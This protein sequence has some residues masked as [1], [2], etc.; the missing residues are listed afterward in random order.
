MSNWL[1]RNS[2]VKSRNDCKSKMWKLKFGKKSFFSNIFNWRWR[3]SDVWIWDCHLVVELLKRVWLLLTGRGSWKKRY[4]SVKF[5]AKYLKLVEMELTDN[6]TAENWFAEKQRLKTAI[7]ILETTWKA[8][9][10]EKEDIC[11]SSWSEISETGWNGIAALIVTVILET[12]WK[13][14]Q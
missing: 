1:H 8:E 3:L 7:M 5:L 4:L 14:A 9:A 10:A 11:L 13:G 12:T 6:W 2:P